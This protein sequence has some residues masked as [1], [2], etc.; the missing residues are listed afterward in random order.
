MAQVGGLDRVHDQAPGHPVQGDGQADRVI[1]AEAVRARRPLRS[2][3]GP[4]HHETIDRPRLRRL[5]VSRRNGPGERAA[6][7]PRRLPRWNLRVRAARFAAARPVALTLAWAT[8]KVMEVVAVYK[9]AGSPTLPSSGS[10]MVGSP[11]MKGT[12]NWWEREM[13]RPPALALASAPE[14][15]RFH[16]ELLQSRTDLAAARIHFGLAPWSVINC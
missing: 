1:Q 3:S 2:G 9:P 8:P 15:Q 6:L 14:V 7:A 16:D 4:V 10:G 13:T 12:S 5:G 11:G